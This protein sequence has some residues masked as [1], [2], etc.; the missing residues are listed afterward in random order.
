[1]VRDFA[2]G[3][4][5]RLCAKMRFCDKVRLCESIYTSYTK[6]HILL[7]NHTIADTV[8]GSQLVFSDLDL[9][10]HS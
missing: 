5:V 8:L 1:M 9:H 10:H 6:L 2:I 7:L 4:G 3:L